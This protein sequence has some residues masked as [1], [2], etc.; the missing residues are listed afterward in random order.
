MV[1][2]S[3]YND[4][5]LK[6][7]PQKKVIDAVGRVFKGEKIKKARINIIY[8]N[9]SKILEL[10]RKYL[11]HNRTTDVLSFPLEESNNIIEGEIY[12][13][14]ETAGKQAKEYNVTLSNEIIRLAVHGALHFAGYADN[15]KDNRDLMHNLENRYIVTP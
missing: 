12:I 6:Y 5:S 3:I 9:D 15:T 8:V 11:R 4:S 1:E 10:N 13:S 14:S 2:I 7:L